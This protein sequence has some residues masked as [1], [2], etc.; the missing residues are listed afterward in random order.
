MNNKGLTLVELLVAII[1]LSLLSIVF[2]R[3]FSTSLLM[4]SRAKVKQDANTLGQSLMESVKA[5]DRE[6]LDEQFGSFTDP[7]AFRIYN[8]G[9]TGSKSMTVNG[10]ERVYNLTNVTFD[11][12]GYDAVITVTPTAVT[13]VLVTAVSMNKYNDA[14][15]TQVDGEQS[16]VKALIIDAVKAVPFPGSDD[17]IDE[18]KFSISD[19]YLN[20]TI[21]GDGKVTVESVYDYA[22]DDMN[23]TTTLPGGTTV[24]STFTGFTGTITINSATAASYSA[25]DCYDNTNTKDKGAELQSLYLYYFPTYD[26]DSNG[27][28]PCGDDTI[29]ITNGCA[30]LKNIYII[31][32]K[33]SALSSAEIRVAEG[34]YNPTVNYTGNPVGLSHNL[35]KPLEGPGSNSVT[36]T[37]LPDA[38]VAG[39]ADKTP[40]SDDSAPTVLVYDVNVKIMKTGTTEVIYEMDGSTNTK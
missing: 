30:T 6:T 40:W 19:H 27:L 38:P 34:G 35:E 7:G 22:V 18:S 24:T 16:T 26:T 5:Y 15:F 3:G 31:K 9:G 28:I 29:Q 1:I 36:L 13:D 20:V 39:H 21:D 32:Q 23:Y 12:R 4:S 37:G 25:Y 33:T 11:G 14:I 8:L 2:L 17:E 10:D